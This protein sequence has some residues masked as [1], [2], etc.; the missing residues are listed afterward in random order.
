[1]DSIK[2]ILLVIVFLFIS[3]ALRIISW[4]VLQ[5]FVH[6]EIIENLLIGSIALIGVIG[7]SILYYKYKPKYSEGH[8]FNP[9]RLSGLKVAGFGFIIGIAMFSLVYLSVDFLGGI[10]Q[11]RLLLNGK[12]LFYPACMIFVSTVINAAWEEYTFRGLV[13]TTLPHK[14]GG[15]AT[16]LSIGTLFGLAHLTNP[17]STPEAI[18]SVAFAGVLIS[19]SMLYFKDI[20]FPIGIHVGWN[21]TQSMLTLEK[22]N[23]ISWGDSE[24]LTGGQYG[25]EASWP[26]IIVTGIATIVFMFIYL[27][28]KTDKALEWNGCKFP[29]FN[30][31]SRDYLLAS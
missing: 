15:V 27:N 8:C 17:K 13:F 26:G 28:R 24:K 30:L 7:F 5:H 14:I 6:N 22:I 12:E 23:E 2:I 18:V 25:L 31:L 16:A 19:F 1:M 11:S 4:I 3:L 21:F 9:V 10:N 29:N 20:S